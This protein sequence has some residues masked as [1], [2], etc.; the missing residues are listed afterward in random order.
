MKRDTDC[1]VVACILTDKKAYSTQVQVTRVG[2]G[3][4]R[5][6]CTASPV[7][8]GEHQARGGRFISPWFLSSQAIRA[9]RLQLVMATE[10]INMSL[11]SVFAHLV[12]N[13][14]D[15]KIAQLFGGRS[16]RVFCD[17][18]VTKFVTKFCDKFVTKDPGAP[19][20]NIRQSTF[21]FPHML[22]IIHPTKIPPSTNGMEN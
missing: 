17:E 9:H 6:M 22:P 10:R 11:T 4:P 15:W 3:L 21:T 8:G 12:I 19:Y 18:F 1:A 7:L 13:Q 14:I 16:P 5:S 2:L 20:S